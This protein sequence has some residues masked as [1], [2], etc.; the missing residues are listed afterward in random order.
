[1]PP[2]LRHPL[3]TTICSAS[4]LGSSLFSSPV[5]AEEISESL[6]IRG[7]LHSGWQLSGSESPDSWSDS[8]YL[9]RA[10]LD[11]RWK[12]NDWSK[13]NL[14][15]EFSQDKFR[16]RDAYAE[17][18]PFKDL[19]LDLDLT[20]GHFKKPFSRLR[21]MSPWDLDIPERGLMNAFVAN[22]TRFGGFGARDVGLMISGTVKGPALFSEDPLKL[23]YSLGGFNSLPS[24]TEYYRDVVGRSQ[25]RLFKG[26]IVALNGSLKLYNDSGFK[27][28]F[29][30][31]GDVKWEWEQFKWVTE[32]AHGDNVNTGGKLW[33]AHTTL[34]Y[35][36]PMPQSWRWG[37]EK[38][39]PSLTPAIMFEGF[40]PEA[41]TVS[42]LDW[43][44]AAALNLDLTSQL[45]LVL[46]L[47]KTWENLASSNRTGLSNPTRL[48]IQANVAF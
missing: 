48:N 13:L 18:S 23:Q 36:I 20:V 4:F 29:V 31:G 15:F 22:G 37:E 2:F 30:W 11:G 47:E 33:G 25:I 46:G 32:A 35:R 1:M 8:F 21:L 14:E 43:R 16:I 34:S 17:F 24:E 6:R 45:R 7:R 38:N 44:L 42:E 28:A 41:N 12:P 27:S 19:G 26:L 39:A 40:N 3:L 5:K 9:R 10:R